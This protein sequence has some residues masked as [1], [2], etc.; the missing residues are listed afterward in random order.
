MNRDQL[1]AEVEKLS[2]S[3]R[4]RQMVELGRSSGQDESIRQAIDA[5]SQSDAYECGLALMTC[6][7]S[8]DSQR[9]LRALNHPSRTIRGLALSLTS[10]ICND[11]EVEQAFTDLSPARLRRVLLKKLAKRRRQTAVDVRLQL[12]LEHGDVELDGLLS[13]GSIEFVQRALG[14]AM[15][16]GLQGI[17]DPRLARWHPQAVPDLLMKQARGATN[18]TP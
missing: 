7:G 3:A 2:H 11:A 8:R 1:L 13:F 4:L 6:Y 18:G 17:Q 15:A 9:V 10:E 16:S 14:P 5:L 12:L